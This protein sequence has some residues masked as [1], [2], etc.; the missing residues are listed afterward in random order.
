MND[1]WEKNCRCVIYY[2]HCSNIRNHL[3]TDTYTLIHIKNTS[4]AAFK[5]CKCFIN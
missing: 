5:I 4:V 2:A 1:R 3:Y